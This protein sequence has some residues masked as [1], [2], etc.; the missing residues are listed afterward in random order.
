[1]KKNDLSI[2]PEPIQ[3]AQNSRPWFQFSLRTLLMVTLI[4]CVG[5][6]WLVAERNRIAKRTKVLQPRIRNLGVQPKW[7][8]WLLG[9]DPG[10]YATDIDSWDCD[11]VSAEQLSGCLD[12]KYLYLNISPITD[13]GVKHLARLPKLSSLELTGTQVTDAGLE[14][15]ATLP[16]LE[17]L[18]LDETKISKEAAMK[19]MRRMPNLRLI[20]HSNF[21]LERSPDD[22]NTITDKF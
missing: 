10:R 20:Y 6:G 11:D 14:H 19:L 9:N 8:I 13:S 22:P 1:M 15:L 16:K 17:S 18:Y 12:L 3:P 21:L 2:R 4:V 5:L 7:R